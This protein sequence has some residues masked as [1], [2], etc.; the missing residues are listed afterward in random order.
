MTKTPTLL[1]A[2]IRPLI[3]PRLPDWVDVRDYGAV[4]GLIRA[5]AQ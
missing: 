2:L 1:S 5:F 3:E 4:G